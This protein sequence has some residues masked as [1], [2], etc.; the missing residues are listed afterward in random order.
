MSQLRRM[1][2]LYFVKF[3]SMI[4]N[5]ISV[6]VTVPNTGWL[7]KKVVSA[8]MQLQMDQRYSLKFIFPTNNPL[9]NNQHHIVVDFISEGH[10][11]WLSMDSDNPPMKNPLDLIELDKDIMGLPTPVWHFNGKIHGENPIYWNG[12]DYVEKEGAYKEHSPKEGLQKVDAIGTGCFLISK[13]VFENH[14]MRKGPFLR[15]TYPDG[16]VEKGNDISF[17]ERAREQGFE[18]WCHYDYPCMHFNE[19]ELTEVIRAFTQRKTSE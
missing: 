9:E 8:L 4:K 5:R 16:R 3:I 12:Y 11:Y 2:L 10:D 17:C 13:R 18:V 14:E 15:K 1:S 7:H 6:L 19:L